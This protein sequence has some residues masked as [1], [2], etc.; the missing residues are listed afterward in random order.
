MVLVHQENEAGYNP[1]ALLNI[2]SNSLQ[3]ETTRRVVRVRG[4]YS[5]GKGVSYNGLYY[6]NLKD[7]TS[8]ACMTLVLPGIIRAELSA[9]QLIECH[10]YLTKKIQLN[11]GRIELQLNAVELLS[12]KAS[13]FTDAQ[14]KTFEIL[15]K[16]AEAG[17][18]DVDG[19][20]K[21]KIINGEPVTVNILIGKAGIIDSDI[22]HQL[23][24][25]IGFYKFYFIRINL[26]SEKEITESIHYYQ[27]KCDILAIARG[28]GEHLE[29][30]DS[31]AIAGAA[32]S[33]TTHFVTAIGH[34][35]DVPVL[36]KIADKSF[37]TPTALG[38]YFNE[39]YNDT[40]VQLQ[41]SKA[42]LAA[43]ISQQ[44]EANYGKQIQNMQEAIQTLQQQNARDVQVLNQQLNFAGEEKQGYIRQV[45]E[46]QQQVE[47]AGKM[48]I[49][50]AIL[51]LA[52]L[53]I[54][55]LIG[56]LY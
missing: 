24:E 10:A 28:G 50:T 42:K 46:L 41:H 55:W 45:A 36:Q 3:N 1:S 51:I 48:S 16:K 17:Y 11:G 29:I 30:F 14:I 40:V 49:Y 23:R 22:K 12:K 13:G 19:F 52:A 8:D 5:A 26:G 7:D 9:N 37:I 53:V 33:L 32:L 18:K 2:F 27:K 21:N 56:Q 43:D 54:G 25:A 39:I 47:K 15:N 35:E 34:K 31:P 6:D 4:I 38:Q 44:L 20:L